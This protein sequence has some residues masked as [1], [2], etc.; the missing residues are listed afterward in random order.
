MQK[1][2]GEKWFVV[3]ETD[4]TPDLDDWVGRDGLGV[5]YVCPLNPDGV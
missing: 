5:E 4:Y 1:P 3:E 2:G